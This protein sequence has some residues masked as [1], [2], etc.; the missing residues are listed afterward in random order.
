MKM[1]LNRRQENLEKAKGGDFVKKHM[2]PDVNLRSQEAFERLKSGNRRFVE[3][4]HENWD[5]IK[6]RKEL[7]KGQHP[8]AMIVDCADSRTTPEFVFDTRLGDLFITRK[9]GNYLEPGDIGSLEYGAEHLKVPLLVVMGHQ[10]CGAVKAACSKASADGNLGEV[11][12]SLQPAVEAAKKDPEAAVIENVKIQIRKIREN[13]KLLR[14][15]ENEGK[16]MIVGAYYSLESG[17]V[18]FFKEGF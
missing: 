1:E 5:V 14:R 6:I 3:G 11:I 7:V 8:F 18:E 16:L 12:K 9:A 10:S 17:E 13:S 2:G 4:K 15:L